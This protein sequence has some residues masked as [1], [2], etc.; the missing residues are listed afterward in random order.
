MVARTPAKMPL[1]MLMETHD[2]GVSR[3]DGG[4]LNMGPERRMYPFSKCGATSTA[5]SWSD[6]AV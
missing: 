1:M 5:Q 4:V 6:E 3:T 2:Q